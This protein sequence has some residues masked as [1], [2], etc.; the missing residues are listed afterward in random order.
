MTMPN[1][2]I[3]ITVRR[4]PT[5]TGHQVELRAETRCNGE[6][7]G[8]VFVPPVYMGQQVFEYS[9]S[10]DQVFVKDHDLFNELVREAKAHL[11]QTIGDS[12]QPR[13]AV[14]G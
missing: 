9:L 2:P 6:R 10:K 3:E 14:G 12:Y 1:F 8:Y 5:P 4:V 11:M 13:F 7:L